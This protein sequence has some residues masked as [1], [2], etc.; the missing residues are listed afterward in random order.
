MIRFATR[1]IEEQILH[2]RM[3][4]GVTY[5]K[6]CEETASKLL[7]FVNV[8]FYCDLQAEIFYDEANQLPLTASISA[9]KVR[10][11]KLLEMFR[12]CA[13]KPFL[14][15]QRRDLI[16]VPTLWIKLDFQR[17]ISTSTAVSGDL[18]GKQQS[19]GV[20]VAAV[21]LVT[22]S[23]Q[24]NADF[25]Q[26]TALVEEMKKFA[27]FKARSD[28]QQYRP[29]CVDRER[30]PPPT[31]QVISTSLFP[32]I[33]P[34]EDLAFPVEKQCKSSEWLRG[35]W[36][37]AI[38]SVLRQRQKE[39]TRRAGLFTSKSK[40]KME[41]SQQKAH[42]ID[43]YTR[44]L[45]DE[46]IKIII[47]GRAI[48]SLPIS[49]QKS[50]NAEKAKAQILAQLPSFAPLTMKERWEYSDLIQQLSVSDQRVYRAMADNK[51]RDDYLASMKP[52]SP[53]KRNSSSFEPLRT[54]LSGDSSFDAT[55]TSPKR[56]STPAQS[57]SSE[58]SSEIPV[59]FIS[60]HHQVTRSK[61]E[62]ALLHKQ[63]QALPAT[64][65]HVHSSMYSDGSKSPNKK[66]VATGTTS[67]STH[68]K[69]MWVQE[70]IF[71]SS[72]VK[73]PLPLI[74]WS[75]GPITINIQ[76]ASSVPSLL[77]LPEDEGIFSRDS[78]MEIGFESCKG[79]IL[80]CRSP[81]ACFLV[82]MRFGL[83]HATLFGQNSDQVGNGVTTDYI[84][85]PENGFL[86]VGLKYNRK[87]PSSP[88]K[89]SNPRMKISEE[90]WELVG[91]ISIG[92]IKVDYN[93]LTLQTALLQTAEDRYSRKFCQNATSQDTLQL[94]GAYSCSVAVCRGFSYHDR[95]SAQYV[96][97]RRRLCQLEAIP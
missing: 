12:V 49:P 50:S 69:R 54:S 6:A 88:T 19:P 61:T 7:S 24:I 73:K 48:I 62:S 67:H 26:L 34:H 4:P 81:D 93:E 22:E 68:S 77:A 55:R 71:P 36:R 97:N 3:Q 1:D 79:A 33:I 83:F 70:T 37:Y 95:D 11:Q 5:P 32:V 94:N 43:L 90:E 29:S 39:G 35:M 52:E 92:P 60:N 38:H 82:E 15:D 41:K 13:L 23:T 56:S 72:M 16:F 25:A 74:N 65:T 89:S 8:S 2:R 40:L 57:F 80:I 42:Y 76:H 20:F 58:F 91:K 84:H 45:S 30:V 86:Y 46:A 75:L 51:I 31:V 63:D 27:D 47:R 78:F 10:R 21:D 28:K 66:S 96:H 44:N 9:Q 59:G 14:P 17:R 85:L 87:N 53:S 18:S 64:P